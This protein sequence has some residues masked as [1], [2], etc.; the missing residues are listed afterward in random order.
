MCHLA[1]DHVDFVAIGDGHQQVGIF[2]TGLAQHRWKGGMAGHRTD[3]QTLAQL[4]QALV[5]G[6]H[7]GDVVGLAG[8][9][10]GEIAADLASAEDKDVHACLHPLLS[11]A[12]FCD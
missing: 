7:H 9:L 12:V 2:G 6:I 1:G 5:I 4:A 8:Q 3:V 10:L 11:E